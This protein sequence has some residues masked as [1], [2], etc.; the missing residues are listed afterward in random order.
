M[1]KKPIYDEYQLMEIELGKEREVDFN[2]YSNPRFDNFQMYQIRVGME[3]GIEVEVFAKPDYDAGQMRE[4]RLGLVSGIDISDYINPNYNEYDM[5]RKREELEMEMSRMHYLG[6]MQVLDDNTGIDAYNRF[7]A[8][9]NLELDDYR[10]YSRDR[11]RATIPLF[12]GGMDEKAKE[13][14][15]SDKPAYQID[16]EVSKINIVPKLVKGSLVNEEAFREKYPFGYQFIKKFKKEPLD[17]SDIKVAFILENYHTFST[18]LHFLTTLVA[19]GLSGYSIKF[20]VKPNF[21]TRLLDGVLDMIDMG[22]DYSFVYDTEYTFPQKTELYKAA[23]CGIDLSN[24]SPDM[25][26]SE[27]R[28]IRVGK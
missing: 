15:D 22:I 6:K 14:L 19:A 5:F 11:L 25:R 1:A 24:F 20:V 13:F 21:E 3:Q 8:L 28:K 17:R 27:M 12:V 26:L 7:S 18:D 23:L 10:V 2:K 4:L 16:Y 9:V